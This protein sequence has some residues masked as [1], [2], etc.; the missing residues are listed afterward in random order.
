MPIGRKKI[1]RAGVQVGEITAAAAGD[2]DLLADSIRALEQQ[3]TP[4]PLPGFEGTHQAGRAGSENDDIV[5]LTH[6]ET[7]HVWTSLTGSGESKTCSLILNSPDFVILSEAKDLLC[8][9]RTG[10]QLL[11]F[12]QD[13]KS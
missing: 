7:I 6:A 1:L 3:D 2:Q 8:A 9:Q 4:A 13:D 11:R 5:F 10:Q 12:A